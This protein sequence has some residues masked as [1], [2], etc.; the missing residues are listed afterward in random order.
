MEH[1]RAM[2]AATRTARVE[3]MLANARALLRGRRIAAAYD[4][5]RNVVALEAENAEA[6]GMAGALAL[7]LGRGIEAVAALE[8]AVAAAP[9]S[10]QHWSNLGTARAGAGDMAGAH[11][12]FARAIKLDPGHR[13]ARH[14][15]A[16]AQRA[17]GDFAGAAETYREALAGGARDAAAEAGMALALARLGRVDEAAAAGRRA[18]TLDPEGADPHIALGVAL[19][20]AGRPDSAVTAFRR[21]LR[22]DMTRAD[23]HANYAR[24][25]GW[26]GRPREAETAARRALALTPNDAEA[27]LALAHALLLG[28]D[29]VAGFTEYEWRWRTGKL[30]DWGPDLTRVPR[31]SGEPF[32]GR[33]LLIRA[34]Q[35][36][37][38]TLQFCRFARQ[39]AA[40]G[41]TVVLEV[42]PRLVPLLATL[43]AKIVVRP[44]R[45]A[46]PAADLCAPLL[47]LPALLGVT[48]AD[49][50][51]PM[52]Y[53]AADP[54]RAA[55]LRGTLTA[56]GKL[57]VGIA[58]AGNP[59]HA[60]DR[61][62]SVE[63]RRL[64]PL[65]A[66]EGVRW[67]S[68]QTGPR[69][70]E[71]FGLP[72]DSETAM[73]PLLRDFADTAALAAACDLVVSVDS[74]VLHLAGA[75]GRPAWALLPAATE[76]RWL[77]G[78]DDTPWY[79]T[80]RLFRQ[81][82]ATDWAGVATAAAAELAA[83][84]RARAGG[85]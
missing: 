32:P 23:I 10:A 43:D 13:A 45:A 71:A 80:M 38:D 54:A 8:R 16:A 5:C 25:L 66:V 63:L 57:A 59:E 14:N 3:R 68:L 44:L 1:S 6:L 75:L 48:L 33:T 22:A 7:Q 31:W 27:H 55:D 40:R 61:A 62:R 76:W 35:G 65:F 78:R 81:A 79:P 56:G 36:L 21:A 50:P 70:D 46:G 77:A 67:V 20:A 37:G 15:L 18:V 64:A 28:G 17:L 11:D 60:M 72:P 47:G 49:L 39:A 73:A 51:G 34:E 30:A 24:A 19:F 83:L 69:S 85:A 26:S 74:A 52:P 84:A 82:R 9:D 41:G 4:A 12:A 58:W 2:D 42:Q 53:L 29:L